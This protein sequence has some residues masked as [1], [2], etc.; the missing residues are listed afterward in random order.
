MNISKKHGVSTQP[1][2]K[3]AGSST[4]EEFFGE[5][6]RSFELLGNHLRLKIF[7][8]ILAEGCDCDINTQRGYS[9][10]CVTGIMEDLKLPQSTVSSYIK[11]LSYGGLIHCSKNGKYVY[12]RPSK[13]ALINLKSFIDSS[14]SQLKYE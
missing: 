13:Q 8:K 11:D 3:E 12:C 2:E 7:L 5:V 14:L 1:Q 10:N 6:S 9:G 4:R